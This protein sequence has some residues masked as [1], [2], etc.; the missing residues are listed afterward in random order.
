MILRVKEIEQAGFNLQKLDC[1]KSKVQ[2]LPSKSPM[3]RLFAK[4]YRIGMCLKMVPTFLDE[5]LPLCGKREDAEI[6][7]QEYQ[8]RL[9]EA[10]NFCV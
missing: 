5:N 9:K 6:E 1:L 2:K 10:R 8:Y 7:F 4:A 3:Q